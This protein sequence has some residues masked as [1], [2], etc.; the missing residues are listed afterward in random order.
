MKRE[1]HSN[2]RAGFTL[3]ETMIVV[4]VIG[5]LA[6][7]AIPS[8]NRA[9]TGSLEKTKASNV[10]LVNQAVEMW[11]M[12]TLA[13]DSSFIDEAVTNY[14]NGGLETLLVGANGPALSNITLRTVDHTFTVS[15]LY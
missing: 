14:I 12:D 11:A 10:R 4:G 9:R 15:D 2:R 1:L 6:A 8:F 3:A 5:L 13:T 7:I